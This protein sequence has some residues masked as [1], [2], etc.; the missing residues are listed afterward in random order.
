MKVKI[1]GQTLS[2]SV[3]DAIEFLMVSQ[4]PSFLG[5]NGT[6]RFIRVIDKLFDML[7]S[8]NTNCKSFKKPLYP[9]D[10]LYWKDFLNDTI[11][12]LSKLTEKNCI[13]LLLHRR[14]TFVLGLI[15][16]AKSTEVIHRSVDTSRETI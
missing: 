3:A 12:Y 4:H 8:R 14:K 2:S 9:H 11:T 15:I 5:A 10:Q 6:I 7:N 16:A 1:A 13:P